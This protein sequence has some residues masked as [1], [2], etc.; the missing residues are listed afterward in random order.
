MTNN[1][2]LRR[3]R[4]C[5]DYNNQKM[6]A[7]FAAAKIRKVSSQELISW[8][9]KD[10]DP[11]YKSMSDRDFAIFL[12]GLINQLRGEKPG[13]AP[14]PETTLNNNLIFRKL[15]IA[16]NFRSDDII[17]I[18]ALADFKFSEHELSAF[19]RKETHKHYRICKDQVL[20]NFLAGL[21]VKLRSEQEKP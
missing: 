21:Q 20:R 3:L 10:D 19:F 7:V 16:F 8:M 14:E 15:K 17:A 18:L 4:Y 6:L 5:L 2:I 13:P 11:M 9:K 12:N 1:D